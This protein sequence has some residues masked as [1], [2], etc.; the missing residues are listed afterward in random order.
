MREIVLRNDGVGSPTCKICEKIIKI[1]ELTYY[2][3]QGRGTEFASSGWYHKQCIEER[4]AEFAVK[5]GEYKRNTCPICGEG[6]VDSMLFFGFH[7]ECLKEAKDECYNADEVAK[8]LTSQKNRVV[9]L[10]QVTQSA[11]EL[12]AKGFPFILESALDLKQWIYA[13]TS[14]QEIAFAC[15][16]QR[17]KFR[18][19]GQIKPPT[20]YFGVWNRQMPR[21]SGL[22]DRKFQTKSKCSLLSLHEQ[23][24]LS[25]LLCLNNL[26]EL[27]TIA[28]ITHLTDEV[29]ELGKFLVENQIELQ[30][31]SKFKIGSKTVE[32]RKTEQRGPQV[33]FVN[34]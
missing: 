22:E 5:A 8:K 27:T 9:K 6:K 1:G 25:P 33:E 7:F 21:H 15:R 11:H 18:I 26:T 12:V 14:P 17:L 4:C 28:M 31:M 32:I 19:L 30:P 24:L 2:F 10:A 29:R 20:F 3:V 23:G 34:V 13:W 16:F